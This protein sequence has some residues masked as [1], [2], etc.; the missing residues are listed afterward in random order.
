MH[1]ASKSIPGSELAGRD[2]QGARLFHTHGGDTKVRLKASRYMPSNGGT[3][4]ANGAKWGDEMGRIG[5]GSITPPGVQKQ[6]R[7]IIST[8]TSTPSLP[9]D[10]GKISVRILRLDSCRNITRANISPASR[11][12]GHG[13]CRPE[14]NCC[15]SVDGTTR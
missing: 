3:D 13:A 12:I 8:K 11:L 6:I 7:I 15:P 10:A 14:H 5:T 1:A 2:E 4:N 9:I